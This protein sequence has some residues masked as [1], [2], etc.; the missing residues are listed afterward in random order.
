MDVLLIEDDLDLSQALSQVLRSRGL[1][2][3]CCAD[4]LEALALARR[5]AFDAIVLDLSLPG[6]DG[7]ELLQRIRADGS[8]VPILIVTARAAIGERVLGLNTGADDYLPKP[9]DVEELEAR[10]RAL[11]RRSQGEEELHCGT[12]RLDRASGV[13]F[14]GTRPLELSPREASLLKALMTRKGQAVSKEALYD[15]IFGEHSAGDV[16]A[17]EVLV[18]RLRKRLVGGCVELMTL[19]GVGYLLIDEAVVARVN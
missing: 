11:V 1:D 6:I 14:K 13:F 9:F 15:A 12:L 2:L 16:D 19:R 8:T 7:L 17:V 18:H 10:L 3:V 5:H 4:G